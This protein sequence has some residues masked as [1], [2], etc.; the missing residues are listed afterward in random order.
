MI[1]EIKINK[2]FLGKVVIIIYRMGNYAEYNIHNFIF[3]FIIKFIYKILNFIILKLLLNCEIPSKAKIGKGLIIFHPYGIII[4]GGVIIGE[5]L[6]LR[7]QV[8]IGNKGTNLDCPEIGD[9]VSIGAGAKIIGNIKIPSNSSIGANAVVTKTF[10]SPG[11]LVGI[12]A[13]LKKSI[14]K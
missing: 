12:P 8:T 13:I 3:Q 14:N 7:H 4:N 9:N 1:E 2:E 5:N 6:I 11:I 10:D